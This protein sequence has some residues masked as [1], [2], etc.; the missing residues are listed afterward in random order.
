MA[1][2]LIVESKNDQC[3]IEA[4]IKHINAQIYKVRHLEVALD[5]KPV[6]GNSQL[7]TLGIQVSGYETLEGL[8]PAKLKRPLQDL[9]SKA[10]KGQVEKIGILLDLDQETEADRLNLVNGC[11]QDIFPQTQGCSQISQFTKIDQ[12]DPEFSIQVA[13]Y[14]T[15][16]KGQGDLETLLKAIKNRDSPYADC[17]N[18]WRSCLQEYGQVV[19]QKEF[20]KFW[21]S[22]YIRWDTCSRNDRKQADRKCNLN[23]LEYVMK[24]KPEIWD[25]D[26]F[27]L[28]DLKQFLRLF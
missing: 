5:Q 14:F 17:L 18:S 19:T 23:N 2:Y 26:H 27:H 10:E 28:E 22:Q 21:V 25:F 8:D 13:C 20:D 24:N 7:K 15:Q 6:Q 1:N 11:L 3:F 12:D 9:K 4:L 16:I